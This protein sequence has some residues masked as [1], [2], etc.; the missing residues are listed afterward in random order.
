MCYSSNRN[1]HFIRKRPSQRERVLVIFNHPLIFQTRS[2][3]FG[4][5]RLRSGCRGFKGPVPPPLW[6]SAFPGGN[7]GVCLAQTPWVFIQLWAR[8]YHRHAV[9]SI[10]A[11]LPACS[12]P[13]R[14]S[15]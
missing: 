5:F 10:F 1:L 15:P 13:P 3:G 4:T 9:V 6:I 11:I 2:A 14:A 7:A 8:I 12:G